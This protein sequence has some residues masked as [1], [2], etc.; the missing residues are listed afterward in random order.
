[1]DIRGGTLNNKGITVLN[2]VE[3]AAC[4][5]E[6]THIRGRLIP[7]PACLQL[8]A[9][10]KRKVSIFAPFN[11]ISTD[12]GEGIEFDYARTTCIAIG[13]FGLA[14]IGKERSIN[15]S[16]SID[17]AKLTKNNSHTS[18]GMKMSDVQGGKIS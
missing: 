1:M 17:A 15:V 13:A 18:A 5:S 12:L 11:H 8:L 3:S 10:R 9:H 16:A 6:K 14:D 2:D 7:T 4:I